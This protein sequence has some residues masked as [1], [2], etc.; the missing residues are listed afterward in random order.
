MFEMTR[1]VY[2]PALIL[3]TDRSEFVKITLLYDIDLNLQE[4]RSGCDVL[5]LSLL[6]ATFLLNLY[7]LQTVWTQIRTDR[8]LI[9]TV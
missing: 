9:R 8:I 4:H 1:G 5:I 7:P 3:V 6:A 2:R